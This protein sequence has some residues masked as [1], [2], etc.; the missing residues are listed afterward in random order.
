ML[1]RATIAVCSQIHTQHANTLCGQ[2]VE[3]CWRVRKI[4][5]SS[6][7][8]RDVCLS[9]CPSAWNNSAHITQ[10]FKTFGIWVFFE[11]MLRKFKF[12]WNLRRITGTLHEGQFALMIISPWFV[13]RRNVSEKSCRRN[14]NTILC[15]VTF[16][17]ENC[18]VYVIMWKTMV[19]SDRLQM[20]IW[21][22]RFP[23]PGRSQMT[24]WRLR[25]P[26]WVTK[27]TDTHSEYVVRI[28][29][30]QQQWLRER[31][32]VLRYTYVACLVYVNRV[33]KSVFVTETEC[34]YCAVRTGSWV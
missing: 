23:E 26:C 27:A 1:Y 11:N 3:F 28:A 10:I 16:F 9:V 8:L 20:T 34:V 15:S 18:P 30:P 4:A 13:R 25:F 5:K 29:S 7:W 17:S 31:T 12:V 14:R 19:E 2:N 6:C 22:L 24:V 21:R 33:V 32:S